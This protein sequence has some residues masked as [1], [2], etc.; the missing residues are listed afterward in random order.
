MT[1]ASNG[2]AAVDR[3]ALVGLPGSGKSVV[4]RALAR[5]LGWR[6][7]DTDSLVES[8][9]GRSVTQVFATEGEEGFRRRELEALR[10]A[11]TGAGP[12]V[13]ACGG[14]LPTRPAARELLWRSTV[15]VWLDADDDELLRRLA[16][17]ADRPL[18]RDDPRRRLAELRAARAHLYAAAPLHV[19]SGGGDVEDVCERVADAI[20][21][22]RLPAPVGGGT[23]AVGVS[24][25]ERSYRVEVGSGAVDRLAEHLPEGA[26]RV[27]VVADRAVLGLA[28]RAL[29]ACRAAGREATLV[30]LRGGEQVKTWTRAGRLVER[31]AELRLGR[32]DAVVVVGGGT[33]GDLTGF[34][35]AAYA[36]GIAYIAVPT[37][38]LAMV[39][40]GIGGKTGV[41]LAAGKN[42]AGAF[43]QPRAVLCD[44][45]ALRTLPDRAYRAAVA[46]VVKYPM[47]VDGSLV[48]CVEGRLDALLQRDLDA[49]AEVVRG[50][51]RAKAEVVSSDERESGRR[52]VLNYGHTVG[53]ALE[54]VTGYEAMLHGEAV[55]VG[56]RVAGRLSTLLAGCPAADLD[57][58]D[59]LLARSGLGDL[60]PVD[61]DA[62][63]ERTRG[64][65]KA[66]G[67]TVRWV[68]VERR[69]L[70]TPGHVV[71]E[72]AVREALRALAR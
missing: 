71:A 12:V 63:V 66:R 20:G 62:V 61:V 57:W 65:K 7:A 1:A 67:G 13:V 55:A 32:A 23:G 44:L 40:S 60:P 54:A 28:R 53:H 38:L 45:D 37:T 22:S 46:E 26:T 48:P 58:Q 16:G 42:L 33:V 72:E 2:A 29:A 43:W 39:D 36:R 59:G 34:A 5:R 27:A 64:D 3:V 70:A 68:L 69:G 41:N 10:A 24:L 17:A 4:A 9:A 25:G 21:G 52:A 49:L 6:L 15:V 35:A 8:E 14:G 30:S 11:L 19:D 50:C 31:L 18:L 56:M 47:A 51:C